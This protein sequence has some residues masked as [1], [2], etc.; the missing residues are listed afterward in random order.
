MKDLKIF[1]ATHKK[2]K[3]PDENIYVPLHVGREGKEDLGYQGDNTKD[4]ISIKN[5]NFCELTGLY[6]MWKNIECDYIGLSHYRRYFTNNN[7]LEI[8]KNKDNKYEQIINKSDAKEILKEYDIILPQKRNYY[9]ETVWSH[10]SNAHSIKDLEETKRIISIKYP[11]F[12][13]SF[14][15]VMS[16]KKIHL[17]NM[18][19]MKKRDFDNYCEWLFDIL[20]ELENR[21]D[22]SDYDSYQKRIYGFISERLFNVW[23]HR[24][25]LLVKELPVMS[26]EKVKWGTK[27]LNFLFRKVK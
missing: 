20:F 12:L 22:L 18:F 13:G 16:G 26:I 8:I 6:W 5:P 19:V 24:N 10:Y 7:R 9:I 15:K 25:E 4:N 11:E 17:Y 27:I 14:D 21:V 23:V 2:Y 3:M 1:V